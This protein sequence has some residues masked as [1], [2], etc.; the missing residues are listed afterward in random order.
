MRPGSQLPDCGRSSQVLAGTVA[1]LLVVPMG[2]RV[3][4]LRFERKAYAKWWC[5]C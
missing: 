5:S 4:F 1:R 3:T 2:I